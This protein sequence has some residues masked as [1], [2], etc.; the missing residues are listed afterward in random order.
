MYQFFDTA[1]Y[2]FYNLI[3]YWTGLP[4]A[5]RAGASFI[6]GLVLVA[7]CIKDR[8]VEYGSV[9]MGLGAIL[10]LAYALSLSFDLL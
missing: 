1:Q 2:S 4:E 10:M 7:M 6:G 9:A 8:E 5:D 3:G